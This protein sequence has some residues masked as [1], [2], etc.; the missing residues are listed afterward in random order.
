MIFGI[1]NK[2]FPFHLIILVKIMQ[3]LTVRKTKS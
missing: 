3:Q 2:I 1:R